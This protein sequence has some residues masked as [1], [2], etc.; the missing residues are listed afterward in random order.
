MPQAQDTK[1]PLQ[2]SETLTM[3]VD[4]VKGLANLT[5]KT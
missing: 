4:V 5:A 1:L 3:L 2:A